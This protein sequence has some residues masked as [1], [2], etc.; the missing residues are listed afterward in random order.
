MADWDKTKAMR[1]RLEREHKIERRNGVDYY[2]GRRI[3]HRDSPIDGGVY[4]GQ[5]PREAIVVDFQKGEQL[6]RLYEE[7]K[8]KAASMSPTGRIEQGLVLRAVYETVLKAMPKG[9]EESVKKLIEDWNVGS[10]RKILLDNFLERG[11][12]VCRHTALACGAL[13]ER[14]KKE[15]YIQGKVGVDRNEDKAGGHAWCRYTS[16]KGMKIILDPAQQ[17]FGLLKQSPQKAKWKYERP[18]D[19]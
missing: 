8:A 7:S 9:D 15:G 10:D 14:F 4:L 1:A 6:K 19:Y 18:E 13:L 3:I 11:E 17:Y 16:P 5:G 12:G 2:Q